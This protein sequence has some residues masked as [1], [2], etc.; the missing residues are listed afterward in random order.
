MYRD[1]ASF[2]ALMDKLATQV[3][4][5]MRYQIEC[6]AE[7]VVLFDTWAGAL[8]RPDYL[9]YAAPWSRR[10]VRDIAGLAPCVAFAGESGHLLEDL[11]QLGV[12]GISLD[13][14]TSLPQAFARTRDSVALQGNLDPAA[15][16]ATPEEVARRTHA[17]LNE[18][19]GHAGHVL[20][21][22]HGVFKD[23]EPDCVAA[24][25]NAAKEHAP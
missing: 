24:F 19:A 2:N 3:A 7:A 4:A 6:G 10:V 5:H 9:R 17:L 21:L 11:V 14:R 22:G 23:T 18:V 8:T 12:D 1:S 15:L 16:F 20:N 25:V 13:H